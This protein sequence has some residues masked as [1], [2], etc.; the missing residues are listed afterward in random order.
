MGVLKII[1]IFFLI[2]SLI[3]GYFSKR[4][5]D[6]ANTVKFREKTV[7]KRVVNKL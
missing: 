4:N 2:L 1:T 7:R 5:L 3:F 6:K